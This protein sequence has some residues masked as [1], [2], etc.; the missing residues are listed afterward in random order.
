MKEKKRTRL[1]TVKKSILYLVCTIFTIFILSK[2]PFTL[3]SIIP[4]NNFRSYVFSRQLAHIPLPP[5]TE[6]VD[7]Q[8]KVGRTGGATGDYCVFIATAIL[9]TPLTQDELYEFFRSDEASGKL[10]FREAMFTG[11]GWQKR[12]GFMLAIY[13][14]EN[15]DDLFGFAINHGTNYHSMDMRC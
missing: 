3:I 4:V 12:R 2:P 6:I 9:K 8:G 5:S 10:S 7:I 11:E 13:P 15:S 1:K 14:I